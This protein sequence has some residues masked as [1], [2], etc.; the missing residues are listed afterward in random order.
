MKKIIITITF[1][2]ITL[3]SFSQV[4]S[5]LSVT[6]VVKESGIFKSP[7]PSKTVNIQVDVEKALKETKEEE[8]LGLDLPY[9]FGKGVEVNYTLE[10]SGDWFETEGG[11]VCSPL[12]FH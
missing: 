10:N 6:R 2:I 5:T 11:R 1:L 12:H 3:I 7:P 4:K 9:R 8:S